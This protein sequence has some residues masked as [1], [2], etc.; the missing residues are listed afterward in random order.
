MFNIGDF[1]FDKNRKERVQIVDIT[2]VW[3]FVTYKVFDPVTGAVYKLAADAV[4]VEARESHANEYT[5]R[6]LAMLARIKSEVSEGTLSTI[7]T[8]KF[9]KISDDM[10]G[11]LRAQVMPA[12]AGYRMAD[13]S[14]RLNLL[15]YFQKMKE[16]S[17]VMWITGPAGVGKSTT[18]R[19]FANQ[20]P[21]VYMIT[22]AQDMHRGDFMK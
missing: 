13:T 15:G 7:L 10:W 3:G 19:E 9:E 4:E 2:T 21:Y 18:A 5:L 14:A 1:V 16:D 12:T 11:R 20:T 8:G 22:C 17:S 6:Y